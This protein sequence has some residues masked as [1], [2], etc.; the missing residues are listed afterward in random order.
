ML[1]RQ[2]NSSTFAV[3]G[4]AKLDI[5]QALS[6]IILYESKSL[7]SVA[8][9]LPESAV[10]MVDKILKNTGKIVFSGIGKSGLV[11]QKLAATFSS[12][13]IP[14]IFLHSCDALHGDL[15]VIQSNDIFIALSK[16]ASG[17]ELESILAFLNNNKNFTILICCNKGE[18]CNLVNLVIQLPFERE[19]CL[20]NLA[21]TSSSTVMMAFGDAVAVVVS[22]LRNFD[23]NC[24]ARF[25]PSGVLG[26]RLLL[27]V[28]NFMYSEQLLPIIKKDSIFSEIIYT[29]S[30]KKLGMGVVSDENNGL[31]GIITDGDLRRACDKFGPDVFSKNAVD[32]MTVNPKTIGINEL[33]YDALNLMESF[34]ITSLVVVENKI[35]VGVIHIHDLI[36]SG[37]KG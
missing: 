2:K 14:S 15:G 19:A 20:L 28:K 24:F 16:S 18:L 8:G 1:D 22:S 37:I 4:A 17:T 27:T 21:P 30:T 36:R 26:K 32:I 25:H 33:A 13:G 31:L 12:L 7:T 9:S 29:I 35:V 6:N 3:H 10:T 11:G 5:K 34:H 23:K